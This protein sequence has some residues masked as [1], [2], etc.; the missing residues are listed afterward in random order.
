[1]AELLDILVNN[2]GKENP[3][4]IELLAKYLNFQ[5]FFNKAEA[6]KLP[7]YNKYDISINFEN[8]KIFFINLVYDISRLKF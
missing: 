6:N 3:I 7:E 2:M 1:M 8:E 4:I 5:D